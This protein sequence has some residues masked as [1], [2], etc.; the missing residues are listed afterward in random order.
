MVQYKKVNEE[1]NVLEHVYCNLCGKEIIKEDRNYFHDH[2]HVEKRWGYFS[3]KDGRVD[4]FDL[5]EQCYDNFVKTFQ[6]PIKS[7]II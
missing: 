4:S 1:K 7:E 3:T 6:I 5:C 2:I